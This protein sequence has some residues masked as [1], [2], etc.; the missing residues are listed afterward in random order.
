M[1]KIWQ[2]KDSSPDKELRDFLKNDTLAQ[3][4]HSRGIQT[5]AQAQK[6]LTPK[7]CELTP[8]DA[9]CDM[10]SAVERIRKAVENKE[11]ILIWGDFDADGISATAILFKVFTALGA[12]FGH[13]IPS[14]EEHG[15]GL[16]SKELIK[17]ITKNKLKLLITVDCGISDN[18]IITMLNGLK[19]DAIITDHHKA[20]EILPQAFAILNAQAPSKI[21]PDCS[22]AQIESLCNLAGAGVAYRL[23]EAL[24]AEC[25][26]AADTL[27][28]ELL[29]LAALGTIGDLVPLLGDNRTIAALGLEN[30][31]KNKG[32]EKL[33]ETLEIQGNISSQDVAF[34]LAPRINAAGRLASP[35]D[36]LSLLISESDVAINAAIQKLNNYN[37][38]RQNLCDEMLSECLQK[39]IKDDGAIILF[40]ENWHLGIMGIV[41]SRLV[42]T[43]N[44]PAFL[45]T[46]DLAGQG[47]FSIRGVEPYNI[48][49]ILEQ[50]K[51]LF[52]TY[53]GHKFAGGFSFEKELD[54][55]VIKN[56]LLKTVNDVTQE[57]KPHKTLQ[58]DLEIEEVDED[59]I[60]IISALEPCGQA[61]EQPIF[62]I[63][64]AKL[65][66]FKQV[67]K[68]G[69]HLKFECEKNGKTLSCVWWKK[70]DF[71]AN[72][73]DEL[74]IAFYPK[75]NTFNGTT[76]IQLEIAD[77]K[78]EAMPAVTPDMTLKFYD[79]RGKNLNDILE[80]I[81]DYIGKNPQIKV[82]AEKLS[83]L[84]IISK[85]QNIKSAAQRESG[86]EIMFF[87][88]PLTEEELREQITAHGVEK[89]HIM[90][91]YVEINPG[92]YFES[93][94]KMLKF[95]QN[96]RQGE[97][98]PEKMA[99]MLGVS[100]IWIRAAIRV[101]ELCGA[102]NLTDKNKIE[103]FDIQPD[104]E[105]CYAD[106]FLVDEL[107]ES[108]E[109]KRFLNE[110]EV[111]Y[112]QEF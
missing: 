82:Y 21:K 90:D 32:I 13:F 58:I 45:G 57:T 93:L 103:L 73:E 54:I 101:F 81:N 59:L 38:I 66:N 111:Q 8:Y 3:L 60:E 64:D 70:S 22:I 7:D 18:S 76:T 98:A 110:T 71:K 11:H 33:F 51:E 30:I 79:H 29:A 91:E 9:F 16:N 39:G 20:P 100:E 96:K 86:Q 40:D 99:K 27:K 74:D 6:F 53:G 94:F 1:E 109:F 63:K 42:E 112:F 89:V 80:K 67:G 37:A 41:A 23:A 88:Y 12:N 97:I 87:D 49:E 5:P 26:S 104:Y 17:A 69:N 48:H 55:N 44:K 43:F 10:K 92:Y 15:H 68:E 105:K 75:L 2:I 50:N 19:V 35:N 14:R 62:C 25:G 106:K 102:L 72:V 108:L 65:L 47:R 34:M 95:A 46:R 78:G 84:E 61:N 36:A 28:K 52:L 56:A 83:T 107:N 77:L 4:L 85:F 31:N 24:L